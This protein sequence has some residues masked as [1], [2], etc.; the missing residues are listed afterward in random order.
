MVDEVRVYH[1]IVCRETTAPDHVVRPC[2]PVYHPIVCRETTANLTIV[3]AHA[4]VYH[5]IVCRETTARYH[6]GSSRL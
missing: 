5:P 3:V 6:L 1:P 4:I 2:S